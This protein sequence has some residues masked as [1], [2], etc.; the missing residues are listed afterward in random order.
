M[1]NKALKI[2]GLLFILIT[3]FTVAV[4]YLFKDKIKQK[5]LES[6]NKNVDAVVAFNEVDL[7][8][9]KTF[10]KVGLTLY[11]L[12]IINKAPFEKDTLFF[13][14]GFTLKM[15]IKELLKGK[16]EPIN[17]EG[18]STE[19]AHV[20]VI[21]NKEGIGNY[22][23]A[24]KNIDT[25]KTSEKNELALKF[26]QYS[27]KNLHFTY[28][29]QSNNMKVIIDSIYHEGS[30]NFSNQIFDLETKSSG[31]LSFFI[32]KTNYLKNISLSLEAVLGLD[33][34]NY[35]FTFK[36]NKALINQLPLEFNG[37]IKLLDDAQVYDV[38]FKTPTSS[39]KNF[40]GIIPEAYAGN[41]NKVKTTGD[42]TVNG[43]VKGNLTETNIPGFDVEITSNNA[44]FQYPSLPK[45]VQNIVI[46]SRI[47]N[48][49]GNFNDTYVKL[50]KLSF[51]IDKD[52]FTSKATITNLSEN[53]IIN[54]ELKGVINLANVAKAY[55]VK[56]EKPLSGILKADV[57]TR[58]DMK[59]VETQNY[60][61]I[62]NSGSISLS[63][64]TY[65]SAEMANPFK[66]KQALVTFNPSQIKL[67][68]LDAET[69]KS[70]LQI[71]GV[72]DNFYGFIFKN[73]ELKGNF[74]LNANQLVVADF[75]GT[76]KPKEETN[77]VKEAV[78]I[79]SFLNCNITA[80][81][82]TV[83]YDNL[84]LKN[85]SGNL[86]VNDEKVIL[87]NLKMDVFNGQ[88]DLNGSVST[89]GEIPVFEMDLGLNA[90][91][92][93]ESF[94]QLDMLKS[95]AP[96]ANAVSGKLNSTLRV[97]GNLTQNL[98]P[99]LKTISGDIF[100]QLLTPKLKTKNSQL[101]SALNSN[102]KFID[103]EKLNLDNTKFDLSFKDGKV[104]I[105]PFT[106][107]YQDIAMEIGGT[108]GF[109]QNID[110]NIK[111]NI[112]A[113]YLGSEV[114]N[115]LLKLT[116]AD[117]AKIETV[118]V[119]AVLTGSFGSPKITTDIKQATTNLASQLA[120]GQK[121]KLINQGAN[122]LEN[123]VTGN[124]KLTEDKEAAQDST[125]TATPQKPIDKVKDSLKNTLKDLFKKKK[126]SDN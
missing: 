58:F 65:E 5:V 25:A 74:N 71:F 125:K 88:I 17:I 38:S 117:A 30:G 39:F 120:R 64:F 69:G 122:L 2:A 8:L 12:S 111:F 109:D 51:T 11:D 107:K 44:S 73:Q 89:K 43:I 1:M 37:V 56:L 57:V 35:I 116:P 33:I 115:L 34:E 75:M 83:V 110:Y 86:A 114:N 113:K 42:F 50:N 92:I 54:A 95:I 53:P 91:N 77:N 61:K 6:I 82:N 46:D 123:L 85:V 48:E 27:I 41:F 52:I 49:T 13:A 101:L 67:T 93:A 105:K 47:V 19:N 121:E 96:I 3:S 94:T 70:D 103:I 79:P 87:S 126:N 16:G 81:A 80:K 118:P 102:V 104:S 63:D 31:K 72:L 32:D 62:Q 23:I 60:E 24:L 28:L 112:P 14:E 124:K 15:R 36:E 68:Q 40:L 26:Q 20:N 108:H 18:F 55:P 97:S 7:T 59:S 10:P 45:S 22:D 100:G 84:N 99:D 4:P 9:F 98:T 76:S 21:F 90:L 78:K 106:L 119:N 29:D 66:I